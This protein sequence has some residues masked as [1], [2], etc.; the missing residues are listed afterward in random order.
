MGHSGNPNSTLRWLTNVGN[1]KGW[2]MFHRTLFRTGAVLAAG[3]L[4][5]GGLTAPQALGADVPTSAPPVVDNPRNAVTSDALPTA[6]VNG[7]VWDQVVVGNTVYAVGDFS[8][9]RPAG[10]AAGTN[11]FTRYNA[12]A[13]DIRTGVMTSWAPNVNARIRGISASPDGS[14]IYI[15]GSFTQVNGQTRSRIAAFNTSDGSLNT[16]FRPV[17]NGDTFGVTATN[18]VV[19]IG[20]W[21]SAVSNTP[22]TRLAALRASDG[23]LTGWTPT[24]S[25]TVYAL[26]LTGAQDRVVVAGSFAQLNGQDATSIGSLDATTG[27][28][29]AYAANRVVHNTG[30]T[31]ALMSLKVEGSRAYSTGYWYGGTG[32]FEGALVSD[33]YDGTI[34]N[35]MNCLGDT[36]DAV[37]MNGVVYQAVSYTHLTLPTKA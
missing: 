34:L 6:Q 30:N 5:L 13:Y 23:A 17:V 11:E 33:A 25:G 18:D 29:Y 8:A 28:S 16:A 22:R 37:P 2:A 3:A 19:Y 35:M 32:N 20:G 24:A 15:V 9:A 27:E 36:Y 1:P 14:R 12:M 31:A 7:V 21:F 26:G 4:I 10:A